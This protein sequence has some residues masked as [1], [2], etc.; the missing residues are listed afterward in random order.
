MLIP[1]AGQ[2]PEPVR[3]AH[4]Y[5][6]DTVARTHKITSIR[7]MPLPSSPHLHSWSFQT[8]HVRAHVQWCAALGARV[9]LTIATSATFRSV[10]T[11][12]LTNGFCC[13]VNYAATVQGPWTRG[14]PKQTRSSPV[15]TVSITVRY[16]TYTLCIIHSTVPRNQNYAGQEWGCAVSFSALA[17]QRNQ[18]MAATFFRLPATSFCFLVI[19]R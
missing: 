10:L 4:E 13:R 12:K 2:R 16:G 1:P 9:L 15:N 14:M 17:R 18:A 5:D 19:H 3:A 7:R 6:A 8:R 11:L